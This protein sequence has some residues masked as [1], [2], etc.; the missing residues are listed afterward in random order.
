MKLF[1]I[2]IYDRSV[3][4]LWTAKKNLC[5]LKQGRPSRGTETGASLTPLREKDFRNSFFS[6][7][8]NPAML[9]YSEF[10]ADSKYMCFKP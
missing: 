1:S 4:R 7:F 8:K 9:F 3:E 2:L 5:I 10:N 6:I